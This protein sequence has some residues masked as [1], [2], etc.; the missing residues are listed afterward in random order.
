MPT[1]SDKQ[2]LERKLNHLLSLID[3]LVNH[4]PHITCSEKAAMLLTISTDAKQV[5]ANVGIVRNILI[6]HLVDSF[7]IDYSDYARNF[8][9]RRSKMI[10]QLAGAPMLISYDTTSLPITDTANILAEENRNFN[11]CQIN[12]LT[13]T[14]YL[15]HYLIDNSARIFDDIIDS[16]TLII[17]DLKCIADDDY[18][19]LIDGRIDLQAAYNNLRVLYLNAEKQ[20]ATERINFRISGEMSCHRYTTSNINALMR[21]HMQEYDDITLAELD[22]ESAAKYIVQH[23]ST[24]TINHLRTHFFNQLDWQTLKEMTSKLTDAE[25]NGVLPPTNTQW[26]VILGQ[27]IEKQINIFH[28]GRQTN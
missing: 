2:N 1:S 14:D 19:A 13:R 16:L 20:S 28:H 25:R 12:G 26:M 22:G 24:L 15:L 8:E 27:N 7:A 11:V 23:R 4:F 6:S 21:Y 5:A 9:S 17:A 18:Y 3:T 10:E